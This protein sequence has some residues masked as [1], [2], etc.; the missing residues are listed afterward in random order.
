MCFS[1]P[2]SEHFS[3]QVMY[4]LFWGS[5][6]AVSFGVTYHFGEEFVDKPKLAW[7]KA[8]ME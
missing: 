3:E 4:I 8:K 5:A 6:S 2:V 1:L 7:A